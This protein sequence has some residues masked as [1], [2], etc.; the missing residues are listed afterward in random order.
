MKT[1]QT[2]AVKRS[3]DGSGIVVCTTAFKVLSA[4]SGEVSALAGVIG[5]PFPVA[6]GNDGALVRDRGMAVTALAMTPQAECGVWLLEFSGR[7]LAAAVTLRG[8]VALSGGGD[9][10]TLKKAEFIY[11]AASESEIPEIGAAAAWAG[12]DFFVTERRAARLPGGDFLVALTAGLFG[13]PV[14][15]TSEMRERHL[16]FTAAGTARTDRIWSSRWSVSA[17]RLAE[18][19]YQVGTAAD[20][21]AAADTVVTAVTSRKLSAAEYEVVLEARGIHS[22]PPLSALAANLDDRGDL[23]GRVDY[24]VSF[25]DFRVSLAEGGYY[26]NSLGQRLPTANWCG[27]DCPLVASERFLR[28]GQPLKTMMVRESRYLPGG[29]GTHISDLNDWYAA[30]P[31]FSGEVG[32]YTGSWLRSDIRASDLADNRGRVWTRID[33]FYRLPPAGEQWNSYY[34]T[35]RG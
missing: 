9:G 17:A 3:C 11:P 14:C 24:E 20:A 30:G 2:Q 21:W 25:P 10:S 7:E 15:L 33:R 34:W 28:A 1:V 31:I 8:A 12:A 5:N 35:K 26:I 22:T 23:A 27:N 18:F 4:A 13:A 19:P 6:V 32:D 16:G 29:T